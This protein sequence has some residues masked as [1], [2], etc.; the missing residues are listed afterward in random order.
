M[1]LVGP[2]SNSF[3]ISDKL[4]DIEEMSLSRPETWKEKINVIW[5]LFQ[6]SELYH[7]L[8]Q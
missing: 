6:F 2:T 3:I 1:H 5:T 4:S 8:E 7:K